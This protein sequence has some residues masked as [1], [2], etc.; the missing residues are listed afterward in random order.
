MTIFKKAVFVSLL[1]VPGSAFCADLGLAN[2]FNAFIFGNAT[3]HGGHSQGS[4]AVGGNWTMAYEAQQNSNPR[5]NLATAPNAG[6]YVGGNVIVSGTARVMRGNAYVGGSILNGA[7]DV[8]NGYKLNPVGSSVNQADFTN[9]YLYSTGQST[10]M[11]AMNGV[12]IGSFMNNLN[13]NLANNNLNGNV[14]VYDLSANLLNNFATVDFSG[15]SADTTIIMNVHGGG[16]INWRWTVNGNVQSRIVWNFLDASTLTLER[17]LHGSILA[18]NT[19]VIQQSGSIDGT[20]IAGQW[21]NYNSQELHS[22]LFNGN[23]PSS[24]PV[25][26][27]ATMAIMGLGAATYL[28]RRRAQR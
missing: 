13:L 6:I 5:A 21:T 25:P 3:T 11:D 18:P 1:A 8:Q 24:T 15:L 10:A 17:Q 12:S 27:P 2:S 23:A 28:R 26:E 20:L 22:Y 16:N 7:L 4:I 9:Q 14:K 19:H